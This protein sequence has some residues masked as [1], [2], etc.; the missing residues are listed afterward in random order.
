MILILYK[1]L[2]MNFKQISTKE[3]KYY[4]KVPAIILKLLEAR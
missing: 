4:E 2:M 3:N 1:L